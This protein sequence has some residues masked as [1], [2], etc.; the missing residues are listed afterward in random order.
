MG[1]DREN[2][3]IPSPL[4]A[5]VCVREKERDSALKKKEI[6]LFVTTWLNLEDIL[7]KEIRQTQTDK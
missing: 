5:C 2:V 7:L 3:Y 6:L 4:C 1:M